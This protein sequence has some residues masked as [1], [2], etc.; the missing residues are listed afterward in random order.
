MKNKYN[1]QSLLFSVL[2]AILGVK[3]YT[4]L[5]Y[6]EMGNTIQTVFWVAGYFASALILSCIGLEF[7]LFCQRK[8]YSYINRPNRIVS[9]LLAAVFGAVIGAL[10]QGLY[11][12]EYQTR[13]E[14]KIVDKK[15]EGSNVVLL[16]DSS[17]S[18]LGIGDICNEAACNLIDSFDKNTS[19]QFVVFSSG[20]LE[21]DDISAFLPMTAEN[22][23]AIKE[24]INYADAYGGTTFN[25]PLLHAVE[26]LDKNW[27]DTRK[28]IIIMLTD[29]LASVKSS[30]AGALNDTQKPID[31]YTV[32]ITQ[33]DNADKSNP[34]VKELI[35]LSDKDFPIKLNQDGSVDIQEVLKAFRDAMATSTTETQEYEVL[36]LG[37]DLIV[38]AGAEMYWWRVAACVITYALITVAAAFMY[39]GK[40]EISQILENAFVGALTGVTVCFIPELG[41]LFFTFMCLGAFVKLE[42][43]EAK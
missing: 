29:G 15:F 19:V 27:S 6:M 37:T 35:N 28:S 4:I 17:D 25:E 31:F 24:F 26:T 30:V 13:T 23:T 34:L 1:I 36:A 20:Q 21:D 22:K 42:I 12:L 14:T 18:M 9:V 5:M 7:A 41:E 39:Y 2:F 32:R 43:Q 33:D 8:K 16:M 10:G 40:Q 11:A 38:D 3:L